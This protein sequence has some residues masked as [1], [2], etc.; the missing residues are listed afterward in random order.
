[1]KIRYDILILI[2]T[3]GIVISL[4][5]C[6]M[7]RKTESIEI[8]QSFGN[9]VSQA[10]D[11]REFVM[12]DNWIYGIF[13]IDGWCG[14]IMRFRYDSPDEREM[15]Y[16]FGSAYVSEM[17]VLGDWIF[18]IADTGSHDDEVIVRLYK[19]KTDGSEITVLA[20]NVVTYR[21]TQ[22]RIYY[23]QFSFFRYY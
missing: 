14:A 23:E 22:D 3:I 7:I 20:R 16:R 9:Q 8:T 1:M 13:E 12:Y 6:S 11:R 4:G 19:I 10:R 18:F 5:N 21:L 2:T 15:I 17:N